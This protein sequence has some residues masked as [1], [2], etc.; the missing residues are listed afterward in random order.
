M[1]CPCREHKENIVHDMFEINDW[2]WGKF[3]L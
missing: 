2:L 3:E 1:L